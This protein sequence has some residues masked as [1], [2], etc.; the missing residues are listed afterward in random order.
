MS[1]QG[2]LLKNLEFNGSLIELIQY[3]NLINVPILH[4]LVLC[5]I[6]D[7]IIVLSFIGYYSGS[8]R[9]FKMII[10]L[11]KDKITEEIKHKLL[12]KGLRLT[13]ISDKEIIF[14]KVKSHFLH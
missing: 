4:L 12:N 8:K 10:I 9:I 5:G 6:S 11:E 14:H 3:H 7:T 13:G 2:F 1:F